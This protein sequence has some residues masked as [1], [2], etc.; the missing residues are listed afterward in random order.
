MSVRYRPRERGSLA[1]HAAFLDARLFPAT[2]I[3]FAKQPIMDKSPAFI[4]EALRQ[5]HL[6][7]WQNLWQLED[8]L[9]DPRDK[10]R[11]DWSSA[12]RKLQ[13]HLV[14]HFQLEE[15][16]GYMDAVLKRDPG[17]TRVVERLQD[18]HLELGRLL[19][20]MIAQAELGKLESLAGKLRSLISRMKK[21][22]YEENLLVE[23]AFNL[24]ISA[25]D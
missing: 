1:Y 14:H 18:D 20:D 3:E 4:A 23:N 12:L 2:G 15:E 9:A 16:N 17:Q 8:F 6:E 11:D 5:V 10:T 13:S 7:L 24:D 25:E 21:H 19:N 22:E